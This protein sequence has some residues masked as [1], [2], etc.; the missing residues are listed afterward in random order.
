MFRRHFLSQL[1]AGSVALGWGCRATP[2]PGARLPAS[3]GSRSVQHIASPRHDRVGDLFQVRR[4]IPAPGLDQASP[5]VMLDHFDFTLTPGQRGGLAPHPHRGIETVT[6]LLEGAI[7]HGDSLGSRAVLES[8]GIQWMTAGAGIVHEENPPA[9]LRETGGRTLGVQL[10]VNLPRAHKST[11]PRYQDTPHDAIVQEREA[12]V[13]TRVFA[14]T[15]NGL[16]SPLETY[17]PLALVDYSLQADR[18]VRVELDPSWNAVL[19]VVHGRIEVDG[20]RLGDGHAALLRPGAPSVRFRS[21]GPRGARVLL[22]AGETIDEPIVRGG[23]FVMN[24]EAEIRQAFVDYRSGRMGRV[25]NPTYDRYR[26]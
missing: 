14:G 21:D 6:V 17:S 3:E 9:A 5:W 18:D 24:T 23:P 13:T 19:H 15:A 8:G 12:G 26:I 1:A 7:E 25:P 11:A 10:W 22:A 2:P 20:Q 16:V 4:T